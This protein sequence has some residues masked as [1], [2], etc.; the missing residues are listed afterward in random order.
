MSNLYP[1][2]GI[3]LRLNEI[4]VI[5]VTVAPPS[6]CMYV[7]RKLFDIRF[8]YRILLNRQDGFHF[9]DKK[10]ETYISSFSVASPFFDKSIIFLF[11][12]FSLSVIS[13]TFWNVSL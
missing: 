5:D 6:K 10:A 13:L 7:L 2:I 8:S 3:K 9:M 1:L 4:P 12:A 11:V